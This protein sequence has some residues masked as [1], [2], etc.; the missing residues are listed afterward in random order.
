MDFE[1]Q[2][3]SGRAYTAEESISF[4]QSPRTHFSDVHKEMQYHKNVSHVQ[5]SCLTQEEF[6]VFVKEYA[7]QYE[8]IYFFQ[9]SKV[10]DLSA[11]SSLHN[12]KYLLFYNMR[13][14][15]ALWNMSE[16]R[17]LKGIMISASKNLV[18]DLSQIAMAPALEELLLLGNMDRKYTVK[19]LAPIQESR[20]LKRVMLDCRTEAGDF[21]P[22]EF[23]FELFRYRVDGHRNFR[24]E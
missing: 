16:N 2:R 20:S 14:A 15:K 4:S 18:Y 3:Y 8:S 19:S 10:K 24:Y 7:D 13:S 22:G 1:I 11:L 21:D 17:S 23:S 12:V 6:D 5:V 9:N